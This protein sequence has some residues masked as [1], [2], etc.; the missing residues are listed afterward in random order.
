MKRNRIAFIAGLIFIAV[1]YSACHTTTPCPAYAIKQNNDP[2]H[3]EKMK[4]H[5]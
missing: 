5:Q 2:P 3:Q 4:P 1:A